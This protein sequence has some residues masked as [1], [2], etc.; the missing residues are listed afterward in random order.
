VPAPHPVIGLEVAVD[1]AFAPGGPLAGGVAEYEPRPGQRAMAAAVA[2]AIEGGRVLLAEAGTGTGKTLAYLVPALLSGRRVLVSTGTKTLQEQIYEKDVEDLR[3][4]LGLDIA[5]TCLKG[6]ANYLCLHRFEQFRDNPL[7]MALV[8]PEIA[9]RLLAWGRGTATG[10]RAELD[11]L[12]EDLPVWGEISAS[13]ENCLGPACPRHDDCF[14]TRM[15]RRA[16]ESDLVIVNH[17]LLCADASVRQAAAVGVIPECD[18]AIIDEAHQLEEVA[19]QYFGIAV[20]TYRLE[21]LLGDAA[22]AL[23]AGPDLDE[24]AAHGLRSA[25][26]TVADRGARFF[27]AVRLARAHTPRGDERVR[28]APDSLADAYSPGAAL[29]EALD[30]V[31]VQVALIPKPPEDLRAI[32]RRAGEI[33]DDLAFLVKVGDPDYVYYLESRGRGVALRASPI[34]VS[35]VVRELL[36]DRLPATILTS[37]TLSVAGSFAYVRGR[38]GI[39]DADEIRVPSE[40]AYREQAILYLPARMPDPRSPQ[41]APAATREIVQVLERTEGRAFVLFTSYAM[42]RE[43][44]RALGDTL[45]Y[46]VLVQGQAP[47]TVLLRRFR[48]LGNAVLLATSSFWQGVDVVG[49][50]LS[51]VIIDKIPFASPADP[52]TAAR[53]EAI[54]AK[55]ESAFTEYQ[56]PLAVLTLLQ[57]FGRL[58]RHRHDRGVLALL[59]PR[60]RTKAYGATFLGALPPA[61]V[62]SELDDIRRFFAR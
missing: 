36:L 7:S 32:A 25:L 2:R 53:I 5:V 56:V 4:A 49:E 16:A 42:L 12:P 22:R 10:D 57:G 38:L 27:E 34:D 54:Q 21:D 24:T 52:I 14:V 58:I 35:G 55:G 50:A 48:S 13:A 61:P 17:H 33:E 59:D 30:G 31:Q 37:A 1:A 60:V 9:D 19:T 23:A 62:T 44:E 20:S 45:P 18:V 41:F 46:P 43:V 47:R 40:F 15:R 11:E 26:A 6:R 3:R 39:R 51:C 29:Q 8:E 28:L